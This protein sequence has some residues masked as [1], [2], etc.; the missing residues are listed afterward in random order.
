M[1]QLGLWEPSEAMVQGG[2]VGGC[3]SESVASVTDDLGVV[4]RALEGGDSKEDP[5]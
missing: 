5:Q 4:V 1:H 3:S 2:D